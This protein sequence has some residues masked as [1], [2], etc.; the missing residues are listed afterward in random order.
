MIHVLSRGI[1]AH[2]DIKP[3]NCLVTEDRTLK[4]TDFGLAK[5]FDDASLGDRKEER[6]HEENARAV[7]VS[8]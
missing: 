8:W 2:R 6:S 1:K 3:D 7:W 5:V 4:V